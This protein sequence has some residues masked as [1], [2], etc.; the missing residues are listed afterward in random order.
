VLTLDV[1]P[2]QLD[3]MTT[4]RQKLTPWFTD[5]DYIAAFLISFILV[6]IKK[7]EVGGHIDVI[8]YSAIAKNIFQSGNY[9]HFG[10]NTYFFDNYYDHFPLTYWVTA[11]VYELFGVSDFTASL[12]PMICS[13]IGY[14]ALFKV[15]ERLIDKRFGLVCLLTWALCFAGTKLSGSLR[16]DVPLT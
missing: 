5:S 13:F 8:W 9:F 16:M 3:H 6:F 1:D 4:W 15:G 7:W 14:L 2:C 10:M 12:Y 11:K